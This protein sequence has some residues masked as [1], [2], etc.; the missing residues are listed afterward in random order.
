MQTTT[1]FLDA[2]KIKT[3]VDS[4]YALAKLLG[5]TRA[6][7][8]NYRHR[9][10]S[11][12]FS[13]AAALRVAELLEIDPAYVIACSLAQRAKRPAMRKLWEGVAKKVAGATVL[14]LAALTGLS[15]APEIDATFSGPANFY[16][17]YE[18]L[19]AA[20]ALWVVSARHQDFGHTP[21]QNRLERV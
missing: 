4:D 16:T 6:A 18:I 21:S 20:L 5:V 12:G 15:M 11:S 10:I 13:E 2:V 19:A 8:S 14:M 1:Q 9:P 7:V 3:G 17:L